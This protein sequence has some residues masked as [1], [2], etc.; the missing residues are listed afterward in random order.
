MFV[1][2]G[3]AG[4]RTAD[5]QKEWLR[6]R[7][8]FCNASC[9]K[10]NQSAGLWDTVQRTVRTLPLY[11]CNTCGYGGW[12]RFPEHQSGFEDLD[13]PPFEATV[14]KISC[15]LRTRILRL[16]LLRPSTFAGSSGS[17]SRLTTNSLSWVPIPRI[18]IHTSPDQSGCRDPPAH[19]EEVDFFKPI[20]RSITA[21]TPS[22]P[23][24]VQTRS[25]VGREWFT[26]V[27]G[28]L[29]KALRQ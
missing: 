24:G 2:C 1:L 10:G 29:P 15:P 18:S 9:L 21:W 13:H 25:L 17:S 11:E 12:Q 19:F 7:A 28:S 22:S 16:A 14:A 23:G 20:H 26:D 8:A 5:G 3:P 6:W 27:M 4:L